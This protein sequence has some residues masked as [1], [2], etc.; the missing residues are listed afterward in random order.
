LIPESMIPKLLTLRDHTDQRTILHYLC[1]YQT[2]KNIEVFS[3]YLAKAEVSFWL[4]EDRHRNTPLMLG[5]KSNRN[6]GN[7]SAILKS[8]PKDIAL[9]KCQDPD[10]RNPFVCAF[11]QRYDIINILEEFPKELANEEW[12]WSCTVNPQTLENPLH[13]VFKYMFGVSPTQV[14]EPLFKILPQSLLLTFAKQKNTEGKTPIDL[15]KDKNLTILADHVKKIEG[16]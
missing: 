11:H 3:K 2:K 13:L 10:G 6:K 16:A 8:V 5:F 12:F 7:I 15:E 9:W 14:L 4:L 1:Y